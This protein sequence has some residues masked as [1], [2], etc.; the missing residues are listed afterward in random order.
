MRVKVVTH[1][2]GLALTVLTASNGRV[3]VPTEENDEELN[4]VGRWYMSD[5]EPLGLEPDSEVG[6]VAAQVDSLTV[7]C[8]RQVL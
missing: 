1:A 4:T 8:S 2:P 5:T 7:D 6:K 3:R